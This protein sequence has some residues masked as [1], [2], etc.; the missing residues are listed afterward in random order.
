MHFNESL[1]KCVI[2]SLFILGLMEFYLLPH[3]CHF[4]HHF[5]LEDGKLQITSEPR[6]FPYLSWLWT[7]NL[8]LFAAS[9]TP[10]CIFKLLKTGLLPLKSIVRNRRT[11]FYLILVFSA[12]LSP[13]DPSSQLFITFCL[14]LF[15]ECAVWVCLYN[16]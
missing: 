8:L 11:T 4:L 1:I 7:T 3:I 14:F 16:K 5:A 6:I 15:F 9:W 13:P 2:Y 12:F 10:I